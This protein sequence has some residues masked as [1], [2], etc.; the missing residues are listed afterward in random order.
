MKS[1][2]TLRTCLV[3]LLSACGPGE[4]DTETSSAES[5]ADL[6]E[7]EG[8]DSQND[9]WNCGEIGAVCVGPLGIG[10]CIDGQCGATLGECYRPPGDCDSICDL[11]GRTCAEFACEGAT[12]WAWNATTQYEADTLCALGDQQ[13]VTPLAVG[14]SEPL[15]ELATSVSCCCA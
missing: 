14:C 1:A 6:G 8:A 9:P 15:D 5:P 13:A 4:R 10:D 3:L 2:Q 7:P 12:A 11:D